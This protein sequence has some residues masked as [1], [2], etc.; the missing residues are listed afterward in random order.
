MDI[1][2]LV[3]D[4]EVSHR[5]DTS[6]WFDH[7]PYRYGQ[8]TQ[9]KRPRVQVGRYSPR[10]RVTISAADECIVITRFDVD[11]GTHMNLWSVRFDLNVPIAIIEAA[12]TE[13]VR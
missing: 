13:A 4:F 9:D 6:T 11:N 8:K 12:I 1:T 7:G 2:A 3:T 10:A 5:T